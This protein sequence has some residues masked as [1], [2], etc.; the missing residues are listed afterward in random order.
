MNYF[1]AIKDGGAFLFR[2]ISRMIPRGIKTQI[3]E[4]IRLIVR[5]EV[6]VVFRDVQRISRDIAFQV[7]KEEAERSAAAVARDIAERV[8]IETVKEE[9]YLITTAAVKDALTAQTERNEYGLSKD[10]V[11]LYEYGKRLDSLV[12]PEPWVIDRITF[13]DDC[14]Q[15]RGWALPPKSDP[16]LVTFTVNDREFREIHYPLDRKDI[17]DFF[18]FR[19]GA[20][21]SGFICRMPLS[22]FRKEHV[23]DIHDYVLNFVYKDSLSPVNKNHTYFFLNP[24]SERHPVPDADRR[25]RVHGDDD[26]IAF[27]IE[28]YSAFRKIEDALMHTLKRSISDFSS[29]L[30]WGCGCGRIARYLSSVEGPTYHGIDIDSDN[31]EWCRRH[32]EYGEYGVIPLHPPTRMPHERFDLILGISVFTHLREKE[33]IQW[34]GELKDL[35]KPGGVVAV[36][37]L[38]D[39]GIFRGGLKYDEYSEYVEKGFLAWRRNPDLDDVLTEKEYYR[40]TFISRGY[41]EKTWSDF[42]EIRGFIRNYIGNLQDLVILQKPESS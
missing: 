31:I 32:M 11:E 33:Q 1:A 5:D 37:V 4:K 24:S 19:A 16:S 14:F 41:I 30:D 39:H 20:V 3:A 15:I 13:T 10:A 21:S 2:L 18:W 27:L 12:G 6:D 40:N 17:G 26:E 28:G 9:T 34:L 29:I 7:A 36:T 25:R 35:C 38:G 8:T 42:F 22:E 23:E